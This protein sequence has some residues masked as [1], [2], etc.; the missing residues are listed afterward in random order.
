MPRAPVSWYGTEHTGRGTQ[1]DSQELE[2]LDMREKSQEIVVPEKYRLLQP[3]Q[4]MRV[5]WPLT[6]VPAV[7]PE[8]G[9][10]VQGFEAAGV[11]SHI[12]KKIV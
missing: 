11:L 9:N 7:G 4:G 12:Q 5:K 8:C 10:G 3:R 2:V 6:C 1:T